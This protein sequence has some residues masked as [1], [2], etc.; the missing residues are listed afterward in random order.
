MVP[1]LIGRRTQRPKSTRKGTF[2]VKGS[3]LFHCLP[4]QACARCVTDD[5][6][7]RHFVYYPRGKTMG[8]LIWYTEVIKKFES[9]QSKW[10]STILGAE[11]AFTV[12]ASRISRLLLGPY[13]HIYLFRVSISLY[14]NL[15]QIFFFKNLPEHLK[16]MT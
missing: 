1:P 3:K 12:L 5:S 10:I 6:N 4:W 14:T 16:V 15:I 2:G 8:T 9:F 11:S 13:L 7:F